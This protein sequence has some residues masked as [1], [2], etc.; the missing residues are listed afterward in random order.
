[1]LVSFTAKCR[2]S[3]LLR[4]QKKKV[5]FCITFKGHFSL[6]AFGANSCRVGQRRHTTKNQFC[7]FS[8]FLAGIRLSGINSFRPGAMAVLAAL[9]GY[10]RRVQRIK[11]KRRNEGRKNNSL[12]LAP[13]P[14]RGDLGGG[15]AVMSTGQ[16]H[17]VHELF[18]NSEIN[19]KWA[20]ATPRGK[21]L[22]RKWG[23]INVDW[24]K[25]ET[26]EVNKK[27]KWVDETRGNREKEI[28][29]Y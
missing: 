19:K 28:K 20:P 21:S 7:W 4:K 5:P 3:F 29:F 17:F 25:G 23:E 2:H 10:E 15:G 26:S 11:R 9:F 12:I 16:Q 1:M 18:N 22:Y 13:L 27:G 6:G 24:L 8:V 14:L